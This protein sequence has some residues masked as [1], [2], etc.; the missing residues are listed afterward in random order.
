MDGL[1][2]MGPTTSSFDTFITCHIEVGG[3]LGL[4]L[5]MGLLQLCQSLGFLMLPLLQGCRR[6]VGGKERQVNSNCKCKCCD[7][8]QW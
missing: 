6:E 4:W 8:A 5:G 1:L 2:L 3:S 7:F